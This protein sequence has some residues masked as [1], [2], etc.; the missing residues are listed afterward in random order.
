V[1]HLEN[2]KS[3]ASAIATGS[4]V[5]A[6]TVA[7]TVDTREWDYLSVDAVF[8][9]AAASSAVASILTLKAAD[10][11]A[12][13]AD[14]T[15]TYDVSGVTSAANTSA[16]QTA[17]VNVV[18]FDLDLRGKP[19]YISFAAAPNDTDAS[20]ILVGRLG[21]GANGPDNASEAGLLQKYSG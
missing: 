6:G 1:N 15:G 16:A 3:V 9:T 21:K 4:S 18:R 11:E 14:Y 5:A 8:S 13:L 19:R 20:V 2:S 10:T 12:T 17:G 7:L